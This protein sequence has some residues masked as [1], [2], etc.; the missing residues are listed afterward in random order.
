V[1]LYLRMNVHR[2][3]TVWSKCMRVLRTTYPQLMSRNPSSGLQWSCSLPTKAPRPRS[4][5][6]WLTIICSTCLL[7][8]FVELHQFAPGFR[9]ELIQVLAPRITAENI[10]HTI[11]MVPV[12]STLSAGGPA[13]WCLPLPAYISS[14]LVVTFV[15]HLIQSWSLGE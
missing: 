5:H 8:L 3:A 11:T 13:S 7:A 15:V 9:R 4:Q 12:T 1:R 2:K 6:D 10:G 14:H